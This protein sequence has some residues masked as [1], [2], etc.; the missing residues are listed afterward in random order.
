MRKNTCIILAF[1]LLSMSSCEKFLNE[2]SDQKLLIP[3]TLDD[4]QSILD[5]YSVMNSGF[6]S[7][8]EVS[9]DD[10]YLTE[11]DYNAL[12]SDYEK[13]MYIWDKDN[14]FPPGTDGNDWS[15]CYK[16]IYASNSVLE[17]LAQ[18]GRK[19][20][21]KNYWD[22]L[23][24][25][26]RFFRAARLLD[27]SFVWCQAYD[28][29]IASSALGMPVR[30]TTD[31][32]EPS[33]RASLSETYDFILDD[34]RSAVR[35]LPD[36][37][38]TNLRPSKKAAY[39][40]LARTCLVMQDFSSALA[41]ADSCLILSGSLLDYNTLD[42]NLPYP[43]SL[44]SNPEVL[45]YAAQSVAYPLVFS[46]PKID[47]VLYGMYDSNDL[48]RQVYFLDNGDNTYS[49]KGSYNGDYSLFAGIATDE[50]Y[51]IKA[52]CLARLNKQQEAME[53]MRSLLENRW[54]KSNGSSNYL[55]DNGMTSEEVKN[56]ILEERRKELLMRGLRWIDIKRLNRL[57]KDI[58]VRRNLEGKEYMLSGN[59]LRYALPLPQD[60][61]AQSLLQQNPR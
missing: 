34:L 2:K 40:L 21:N 39:A 20:A 10:F 41:Y 49:F 57:G 36:N 51:L 54:L 45:F 13:R 56:F 50:V 60:I 28:P 59:D 35:L 37:Q 48:R 3:S 5:N 30:T 18:I 31:F 9:A 4:V 8:G 61:I 1:L 23:N 38:T 47:T 43:I 29:G 22:N 6:C 33:T 44:E 14:L 15:N 46:T 58:V 32:N 27:A 25:Q 42:A 53:W 17:T 16:A 12:S 55:P 7:A 26:A 52:E 24:G 11:A 19:E